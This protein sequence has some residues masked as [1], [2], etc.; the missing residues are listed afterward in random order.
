MKKL[1]HL[2]LLALALT[3]CTT[4]T[5]FPV[6]STPLPA[7]TRAAFDSVFLDVQGVSVCELHALVVAQ[8]DSI[9]YERYAPGYSRDQLHICWSASKTFT[10][11]AVGLA[12][13]DGLVDIDTPIVRYFPQDILPDTLSPELS[14]LTLRHLLTMSSGWE[15]PDLTTRIRGG[16]AFDAVH[17]AFFSLP[18]DHQPGTHWRYNNWDSYMAAAVVQQVT[19]RSLADYLE[20]RIFLP[21]GIRDYIYEVDACGRNIGAS[22]LYLSPESLLRFGQLLLHEGNWQGRQLLDSEWVRQMLSCQQL[23]PTVRP[24]SDWHCGYGYQIWMCHNGYARIDGMWGQYVIIM[25]DKDAVAVMNSLC[26]ERTVQMDSFWQHVL[27]K[28]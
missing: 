8:H 23:Q 2:A 24:E 6:A 14:V 12:V 11:A 18:F 4:D 16:A 21:I 22:G 27:N 5:S 17:E 3:A 19:G 13:K 25:P 28:L 7:D 26:T 20:E 1:V 10:A 9:I 15:A